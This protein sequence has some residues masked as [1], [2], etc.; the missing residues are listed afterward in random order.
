MKLAAAHQ[1]VGNVGGLQK[2][3]F[4][5]RMSRQ[6]A[7]NRDEDMPTLRRVAPLEKLAHA[8]LKHLVSMK[9]CIFAQ[10]CL[11]ERRH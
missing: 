4:G 1:P 5:R 10:E 3:A 11:G 9:S 2:R 8:C 6:I 7:R